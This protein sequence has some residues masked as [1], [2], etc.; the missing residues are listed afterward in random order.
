MNTLTPFLWFDNNAADA[1]KL[2]SEVFPDFESDYVHGEPLFLASFSVLGQKFMALNGGPMYKFT[3]AVSFVISCDTQ[4]EIDHY[5]SKLSEGGSE[6][7]CGWLKDR[8]G[9][10]WQVV[11]NCLGALM[12]HPDAQCR[13][14]VHE[15]MLA[16]VKFDISRLEAAA[17]GHM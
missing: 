8:F 4:E 1:L 11:P 3:E 9:V 10:S 12:G 2:Y 13:A 15:E 17:A 16:S 7:K 6:Q 14:R 5:W